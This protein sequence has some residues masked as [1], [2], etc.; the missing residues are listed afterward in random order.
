MDIAHG[1]GIWVVHQHPSVLVYF[2]IHILHTRLVYRNPSRNA[3]RG[4]PLFE[5]WVVG[6]SIFLHAST[7]KERAIVYFHISRRVLTDVI[8]CARFTLV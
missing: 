3:L 4:Q 8:T 5:N 7:S 6:I 2:Y 1:R